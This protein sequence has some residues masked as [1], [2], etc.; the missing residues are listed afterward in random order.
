VLEA[1]RQ[2]LLCQLASPKCAA[3]Q[4]RAGHAGTDLAAPRRCGAG[5]RA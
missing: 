3:A 4:V 5:R 2:Q 1:A